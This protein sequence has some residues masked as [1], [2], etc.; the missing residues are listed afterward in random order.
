M[1]ATNGHFLAGHSGLKAKAAPKGDVE[2][3]DGWD[4]TLTLRPTTSGLWE[5]NEKGSREDSPE[6]F[7]Q[8]EHTPGGIY[9]SS[10]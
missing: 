1:Q 5:E 3:E 7:E 10:S 8:G 2:P 4:K 9:K 6:I